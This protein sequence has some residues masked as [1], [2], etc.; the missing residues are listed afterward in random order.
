MSANIVPVNGEGGSLEQ[1]YAPPPSFYTPP[2]G[3]D[4][5]EEQGGGGVAR[6]LSAVT[7]YR[8]LILAVAIL[9]SAGGYAATKLLKPA[10]DVQAI[11][12]I[13][14]ETPLADNRNAS[15]RPIRS[16]ELLASASW[17]ELLKSFTIA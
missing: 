12:W 4:G 5:G 8:W 14:S 13:T 1:S 3:E 16:N 7:R 17:I 11:I 9:G 2:V 10:Y 6:I 15:G